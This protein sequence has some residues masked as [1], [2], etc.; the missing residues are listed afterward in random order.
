M[1]PPMRARPIE[2][3][4]QRVARQIE[5]L[6]AEEE[7]LDHR[8]TEVREREERVE[9]R[10]QELEERRREQEVFIAQRAAK[11]DER[12]AAIAERERMLDAR[13]R[14][15]E[16]TARKKARA[17]AQEAVSLAERGKE[18]SRREAVAGLPEQPPRAVEPGEDTAEIAAPARGSA[19][20][21]GWNLN[22]LERLVEEH[23]ASFPA[24]VDEWRYYTL[25]LRE[26]ADIG[27][28][29]PRSFDWLVW[30]AFGDLL[31]HAGDAA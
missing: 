30:D 14:A 20:E 5:A 28:H 19:P 7:K 17:L 11:L 10:L 8:R 1:I 13:E 4:E 25:Y 27:G 9:R 21:G 26:F 12:E 23:A 18:V 24:R 15:L 22:R 31:Q 29:L 16:E 2:H 6:L 3:R